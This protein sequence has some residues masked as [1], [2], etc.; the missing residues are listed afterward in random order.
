MLYHQ[1]L[2]VFNTT[3]TILDEDK[4]IIDEHLK[5][6]CN[7]VSYMLWTLEKAIKF[8]KQFYPI[9]LPIFELDSEYKIVICDFFRY[10]IMYHFG[11]LYTDFD[12]LIIKPLHLLINDLQNEKVSFYPPN[13]QPEIILSEE[14]LNSLHKTNSL[15]NGIL[16]SLRPKHPF[17]LKLIFEIFNDLCIQQVPILSKDDVYTLTGPRKLAT[18][19]TNNVDSF[20]NIVY[21]PYFYFCP[22]IASVRATNEKKIYNNALI[23]GE[24][25]DEQWSFFNVHQYNELSKMCPESYFVCVYLG[26]GSMW[27]N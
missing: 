7:G 2:F 24:L 13:N 11:G 4:K 9:F 22:Y 19:Y 1:I 27:K 18:F 16:I 17:W 14:W 10:L 26:A 21:L 12:F 8:T 5:T 6:F 15:H 25:A 20:R 23:T 3:K